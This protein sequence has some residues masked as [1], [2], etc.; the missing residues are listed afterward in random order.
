MFKKQKILEKNL[1]KR[2][3]IPALYNQMS[4]SATC[5]SITGKYTGGTP[6]FGIVKISPRFLTCYLLVLAT[7]VTVVW[8]ALINCC[9]ILTSIIP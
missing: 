5:S 1:G 6:G 7:A 8:V 2:P 4:L 9:E 3:K